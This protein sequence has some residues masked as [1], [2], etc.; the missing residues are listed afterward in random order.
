MGLIDEFR[1]N[2]NATETITIPNPLVL[3]GATD[4]NGVVD[5]TGATVTG[6]T[7]TGSVVAPDADDGAAL[8][9]TS[10]KW[11]DL[12]LASGGVINFASGDVTITHASNTLAVAGG[13]SYTFDAAVLPATTDGAALGSAT[14]MWS[15]LFLASGGII[16]FNN[17][18]VT[19]THA[20]NVLAIAGGKVTFDTAPEPATT[21]S[22]ALGSGTVMWSDLFL[23]SGGVVNFNNGNMTLTHSTGVVTLGGGGLVI[24]GAE[25]EGIVISTSTPTDGI[26]VSSACADGIELSGANTANAINISGAQTGAGITIAGT[27]GTYGLNIAGACT[28]AAIK[29][30]VGGGSVVDAATSLTICGGDTAR[31][32]LVLY[33]SSVVTSRGTVMVGDFSSSYTTPGQAGLGIPLGNATNA[34]IRAFIVAAT[35]GTIQPTKRI[36]SSCHSLVQSMD[37]ATTTLSATALEGVFYGGFDL[38]STSDNINISA[39]GGWLYL[40]GESGLSSGATCTIG[41]AAGMRTYAAGLESF[42]ALPASY[43]IDAMGYVCGLKL[44]NKFLAP[45]T[46]TGAGHTYAIFCETVDAVGYDFV[47]GTN[48]MGNGFTATCAVVPAVGQQPIAAM[49]V[50]IAGVDGFIQVFANANWT[51]A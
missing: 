17:G 10:L 36:E 19:I 45:G 44:S 2:T 9:S 15:D 33:G 35:D 14:V 23:A 34:D 16:N 13:T 18:D 38:I 46:N 47:Y 20:S 42:V 51:N 8:G 12:F 1:L 21:D 43:N 25:A 29:F 49:K 5:F 40:D 41:S 32:D 26:L 30:G 28:T 7:L 27:C 24:T 6:M 11:S 22:A 48:T 39:A 50:E 31:D 37:W 3:N 4:F